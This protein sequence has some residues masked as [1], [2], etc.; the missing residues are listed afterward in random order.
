MQFDEGDEDVNYWKHHIGDYLRDA[1]HLSLLEHGVYF[2]LLQVYYAREAALPPTDQTARLI[3]ARSEAEREALN[4]V[5]AEFFEARPDGTWR[6]ERCERELASMQERAE[7][8]REVGRLGGRPPKPTGV[9]DENPEG[10]H[11]K[12]NGNPSHKPLANSQE[13]KNKNPPSSPPVDSQDADGSKRASRLPADWRPSPQGISYAVSRGWSM[14]D[15]EAA[16]EAFRDYWIAA[17]GAAARKVDWA[18][19]WRTWLRRDEQYRSRGRPA[20]PEPAW[21][22]EQRSWMQTLAPDVAAKSPPAPHHHQHHHQQE[23]FDVIA[24]RV[25]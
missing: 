10:F 6:Q 3:A 21:R 18:A 15:I 13:E 14:P 4:T 19:A 2:R 23:V 7:R 1:A 16:A 24:R 9:P 22:S 5:L 20:A 25:D 11:K 8:N 12:P 17:A